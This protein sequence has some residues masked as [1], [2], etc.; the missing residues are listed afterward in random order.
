MVFDRLTPAVL[1]R[2]SPQVHHRYGITG[3][4]TKAKNGRIQDSIRAIG[5]FLLNGFGQGGEYRW[6]IRSNFIVLGLETVDAIALGNLTP[7]GMALAPPCRIDD[8]HGT[9][10]RRKYCLR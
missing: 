5:K 4:R 8:L 7:L 10:F 6:E 1:F 3:A 9:Q 2:H